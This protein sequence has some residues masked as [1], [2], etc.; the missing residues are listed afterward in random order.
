VTTATLDCRVSVPGCG[1]KDPWTWTGMGKA[2]EMSEKQMA[3]QMGKA[4]KAKE[5]GGNAM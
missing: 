4:K 5:M 1:L 2:K 3:K